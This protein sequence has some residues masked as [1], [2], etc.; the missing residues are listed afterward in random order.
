MTDTQVL[1]WSQAWADLVG[2]DG[3][4]ITDLLGRIAPAMTDDQAA[5]IKK[6]DFARHGTV[7][8]TLEYAH[9]RAWA[10]ADPNGLR[11]ALACALQ[12]V[13]RVI[14][15]IA[16]FDPASGTN[17]RWHQWSYP[18]R[19]LD[20][21]IT[22]LV[23]RRAA[24]DDL[25]EELSALWCDVFEQLP[26]YAEL[27][28]EV[29]GP[30]CFECGQVNGLRVVT[31]AEAAR[32]AR[33]L[34]QGMRH[35]VDWAE[36]DAAKARRQLAE[37]TVSHMS[38]DAVRELVRRELASTP[39]LSAKARAHLERRFGITAPVQDDLFGEAL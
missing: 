39:N 34:E 27:D 17:D 33:H 15:C 35:A 4:I 11:P 23:I 37:F 32:Y 26:V 18:R 12:T 20:G 2:G 10:V 6:A 13:D 24:P 28:T 21:A 7:H 19:A 9:R 29:P 1:H 36:E 16:P 25:P 3:P 31:E 14:D 5:Q 38:R 22:A 8:T 30:K